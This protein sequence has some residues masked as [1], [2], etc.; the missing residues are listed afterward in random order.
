M[1]SFTEQIKQK[2]L[3]IGFHKVGIVRAEPLCE[4]GERLKEWLANDYHGEMRWME[5]EP[6]TL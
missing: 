1:V 5:R 2:A 3:E 4:E 6:K